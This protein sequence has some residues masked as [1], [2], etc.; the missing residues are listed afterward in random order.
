[1]YLIDAGRQTKVLDDVQELVDCFS[2]YMDDVYVVVVVGGVLKTV[3]IMESN[4]MQ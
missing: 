3:Q 1:M 4:A 2:V